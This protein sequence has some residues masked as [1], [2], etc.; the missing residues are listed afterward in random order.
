VQAIRAYVH[1]R[2]PKALLSEMGS[3]AS[4]IAQV[5]SDVRERLPDLPPPPVLDPEQARFR[6]FDSI[7]TFLKNAARN[8]PLVLVLDDL[9]WADKPSLLLLQF[10]ASELRGA[11]LLVVGTYRDVELRRQHPLSQTLGELAREQLSQRIVLRGLAREDVARFIEITAG[12]TPPQALVEAVYKETEGNPFFVNEVV[13]LLVTDGRLEHPE[14]VKSWSVSIPQSVREVV[15][16]RLDHLSG[17]CNRVLTIASVIGREFELDALVGVS[18]LTEDRLIEVL[19]EAVAAR[20]VLELPRS[21][22]RYTFTHALIRETLYEELTTT[23]RVRLHRQVAETLERLYAQHP[24]P[25]LAELAYHFLEAAQGGEVEK[26]IDYARRAGAR[27][28][29]LLAYEEAAGH[30][31][32]ALQAL[33][34]KKGSDD[35]ERCDLLLALGGA[36]T[37]ASEIAAARETFLRAADIARQTGMPDRLA[38]AAIGLGA[39]LHGFWG[40]GAGRVD[41]P[42]VVLLEEALDKLPREDSALRAVVLGRLAVGLY[43]S[44]SRER[45]AAM[46]SLGAE[47][48]AMA[49]RIGDPSVQ[50]MC[51]ASRRFSD[52]RP[53]N[54]E[55]RLAGS[56]EIVRMA[57]QLHNREIELLGHA[58]RLADVL[59][60]GD[61]AATE[62]EIRAFASLAADLRQPRYLWWT[63]LFRTMRSLLAGDFTEGERLAQ[64]AL[65]LGQQAGA[66]DVAQAF[67]VHTIT[68]RRDLGGL[69]E[70]VAATEALSEEYEAVPSWRC[71]FAMLLAE[72]G[73]YEEARRELEHLAANGFDDLPRDITWLV[74]MALLSETS[75]VVGYRGLAVVLYELLR[76]YAERCIV[77]GYGLACWGSMSR[78]LGLLA[79][80]LSRWDE[81]AGHFQRALDVH[82]RMGA[83]PW[84][85]RTQHDYAAML[86]TRGGPGDLEKALDLLARALDTAQELGEKRSVERALALKLRAMGLAGNLNVSI[87][88]VVSL[89]QRERPDLRAHAAPDGTVTILFT[90]IEGSAALTERLGDRQAHEVL[91]AHNC[92]VREQ[93]LAHGGTEVKSQGDGFMVVFQSARRAVLSAIAMQQAL[94]AFTERHPETPLHIRIGLHTGEAIKEA[95]DFFGKTVILAACIAA[96]AKG[97][98]ILVSSLLKDIAESIPDIRFGARRELELKGLSGRYA[99]CDVHW[100]RPQE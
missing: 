47:A 49:E 59:E 21:I 76:P 61:I 13:R 55:E 63:T 64:E 32:R 26:A 7:T 93:I 45:R 36:Q 35:F 11:R 16:R 84:V 83:R 40:Q 51:L 23:R 43:W 28:A 92:I 85:V 72:V 42:L 65:A 95:D 82:R 88:A 79:T 33:D 38:T 75:A 90:D 66:P 57:R 19:D 46:V 67:G 29:E 54:V 62:E 25:Y 5:V 17:E 94:Q 14:Q 78:H 87:D 12:L 96:Q 18:N 74:S 68:S 77:F 52:W 98:E 100:S 41:E 20:V 44:S 60:L 9:H 70:L 15:G 97:G 99:L 22:G 71:G 89:V 69:E 91:H 27:A 39:G 31:E 81:A 24:K 1:G 58:F 8:Q 4:E 48:V 80:T 53:E 2:N 30:Y 34:M 73:R 56:T 37:G 50:L 3:G 86:L 10:L 6:L